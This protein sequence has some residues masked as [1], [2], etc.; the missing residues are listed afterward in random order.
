MMRMLD[1]RGVYL[2]YCD[3]CH[4]GEQSNFTICPKC[5]HDNGDQL[6]K[7]ECADIHHNGDYGKS[8]QNDQCWKS[9]KGGE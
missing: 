9:E 4:H 8:C 1:P 5:D 7:V 3:S 6:R 2:S